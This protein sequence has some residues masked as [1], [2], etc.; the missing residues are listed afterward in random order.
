MILHEDST[1]EWSSDSGRQLGGILVKSN[2][3]KM[4]AGPVR[5]CPTRLF[6][7]LSGIFN[8]VYTYSQFASMIPEQ[9]KFENSS[10]IGNC[11]AIG[12]AN[13]AVSWFIFR[14]EDTLV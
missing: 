8:T 4:A 13:K 6:C 14:S 5:E 10:D 11:L 7:I 12:S 2:P 3:E 9:P 1:L